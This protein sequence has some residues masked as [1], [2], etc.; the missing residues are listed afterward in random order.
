M[1][2]SRALS[3]AGVA[4]AAA[5]LAASAL[6][7]PAGAGTSTNSTTSSGASAQGSG[8]DTYLVL[9][10]TA[11]DASA[12]A[13][14]LRS[15][16]AT[17]TSVNKDI[18][19]VGVRSDDPDFRANAAAVAGVQGVAADRVIGRAPKTEKGQVEREN[20]AALR[21]GQKVTTGK[22]PQ[23]EARE[24]AQKDRKKTPK[25]GKGTRG[26]GFTGDPLDGYLWGMNMIRADLAHT[27]T[28]GNAKV[29]VGVMDTGVDGSHPDIK[30]NFDRS[31]SR[32][33]VE[34]I[35]YDERGQTVDGP[36]EFRGC[37][38][39]VGWDDNGHGTHVAGTIA[40]AANGFGVSGVAPR[41]SIVEVRAGQDSGYFFS[42]PTLDALTYSGDA[43]LDVVNMSFYVD[44]WLYNCAG[45]A[46][47]DTPQEAADQDTIRASMT[48]ALNYA[49]GK[50]VTLV[51]A[52]GNEHT[53]MSKPGKDT[54]SPDFPANTTHS[55]TFDNATCQNLPAEGPHVLG[56][57]AL[58]PSGTKAD[59]SNYTTDPGSDEVELSAPGGWF[60][61]YF[62]TS[63]YRTNDN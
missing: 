4:C 9:T 30:P 22:A 10:R 17:V 26:T 11:G 38:D 21:A 37:V 25:N 36:C 16:G 49:H 20:A 62:G 52:D 58:G 7:G 50:G 61:D 32:N 31:A 2:H 54:T 19:V 18:G 55:R 53:D 57:T 59:Y 12:V 33:F 1:R 42:L 39:P 63:K 6:A 56:I 51:A 3:Q 48:R 15:N 60:R 29:E 34:D 13:T 41:A 14:K 46:P 40:A 44:P 5:V 8:V 28:L 43:G 47:E 45:G 23:K 24:E 27:K 35:P